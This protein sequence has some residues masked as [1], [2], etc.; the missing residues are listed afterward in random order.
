MELTKLIFRNVTRHRLRSILTAL[1]IA[2]A[3]F[4]FCLI[5]SLIGAWYAGV[6]ASAK[7]R[8]VVRNSV[9]LVFYL[10][11]AYKNTIEQVPGIAKVGYANWFGGVYRDERYRFQQFAVSSEYLDLYPEFLFQ[12]GDRQAWAADRK[13]VLVG[14]ELQKSFGLKIGDVVTLKGTIFPGTWEFTVRGFFDSRENGKDTRLMYFH[15]EYLNERNRQEIG[16]QPDQAGFYVVELAAGANPAEVSRAI[17]AR[18]ANS[19]AETLSETETA[20]VQGFVSMS[21][22][23]IQTLQIVSVVVLVIMLLVLANTMQMGFRERYREF[24][25][26]KSLGFST[27]DLA[28]VVVGEASMLMLAGVLLLMAM[29]TPLILLPTRSLLGDLVNFF[30]VFR[31][32]PYTIMLCCLIGVVVCGLSSLVPIRTLAKLR[33]SDG[34]RNIG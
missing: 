14:R 19:F 11:L 30:P 23:I 29:L 31:I 4:A 7:N 25:V 12:E 18:F 3:L 9:S 10:P 1:G 24:S 2:I 13:G 6:E 27:M 34:L 8:L 32:A 22:T 5:Q 20:F 17:D 21:S 16:R 33:I 28:F 26:L 15:W